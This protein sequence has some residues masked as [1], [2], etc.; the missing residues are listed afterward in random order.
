MDNITI[1]FLI[2]WLVLTFANAVLTIW[3]S[4]LNRKYQEE[5]NVCTYGLYIELKRYNDNYENRNK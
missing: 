4:K 5:N 1:V 3:C 2:A